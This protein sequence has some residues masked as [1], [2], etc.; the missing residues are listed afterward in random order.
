[1]K[2]LFLI[3]LL[4]NLGFYA[5]SQGYLPQSADPADEAMRTPLNPEKIRVLNATQVAALPK[6][7]P[8]L[9]A[10]ACMEWGNFNPADAVKAEQALQSLA[11]GDRL[12]ERRVEET[13]S[14]WV[15]LPPQGSKANAD[16]KLGE[17]KRLGVDD[18]YTIQDEGRF[19]FAI[20]LGVFSSKDGA[21]KRLEAV[22]AKGVRTAVAAERSS[23]APKVIVQIRDGGDA[24]VARIN[25]IKASYP[26]TEARVCASPDDKAR[27]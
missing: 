19:K 23:A 2:I 15:Y 24:V 17:L 8:V 21:A 4:A 3:L 5:Y 1:M 22:R 20:S 7:K 11:L 18:F 26:G 14:W 10:S 13:A 16:K 12:S 6:V 25:E 27:S 9:K